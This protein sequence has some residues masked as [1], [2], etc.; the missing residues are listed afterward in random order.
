MGYFEDY[1][2]T[3]CAKIV[4]VETESL[5]TMCRILMEARRK[6]KKVIIVGNGA[7]AAIASHVS[8]D[9]TKN[10]GIR[11]INF[12]EYDLITCLANDYGYE[13]WVEKA[14]QFYAE[15]DDVIILISSSGSSENIINAAKKAKEMGLTVITLSGFGKDNPLKGLGALNLWVD[16]GEYNI[17][18]TIHQAWLLALVDKLIGEN[19]K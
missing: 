19:K 5:E 3:M 6:H 13:K 16:S 11:T 2:K 8:V 10:A 17:I 15:A 4:Q 14:L 9:L 1:F 7:S 18:E 12:N